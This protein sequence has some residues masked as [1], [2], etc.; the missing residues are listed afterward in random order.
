MLAG[1]PGIGKTMLMEALASE[2]DASSVRTVW[3]RCW[4]GGG[5]PAYW[6]WLQVL[7]RLDPD[8]A[9]V[10][11]EGIGADAASTDSA[12]ARV[13]VF[14]RVTESLA[15][16]SAT[17]PLLL[18]LDDLHAASAPALLLLRFLAREL[19]GLP[20]I[21]LGAFREGEGAADRRRAGTRCLAREGRRLPLRG[22]GEAEV[23]RIVEHRTGRGASLALARRVHALTEGN[24]LFVQEIARV[25][26]AE[27]AADEISTG[28]TDVRM[29][30]SVLDAIR[31]RL[32]ALPSDAADVL[33]I[34]A[35]VG[36]DF[37]AAL[38]GDLGG[39]SSAR[40]Q[41]RGRGRC[42]GRGHRT[43]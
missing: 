1:E 39:L 5:A 37:D 43:G 31:T 42:C 3:G 13:A 18:A 8:A 2:A 11:E 33:A 22:L 27:L 29:P 9:A 20:A 15:T 41:R 4:E 30:Q 21:V 7:E 10:L 25:R 38:L 24:P 16:A 6:P 17:R 36:R 26:A 14:R 35:V 12:S 32:D 34:A 28:T 40:A 19:T 23:A